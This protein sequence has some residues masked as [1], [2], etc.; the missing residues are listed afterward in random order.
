MV[1]GLCEQSLLS[2]EIHSDLLTYLPLPALWVDRLERAGR[3]K[4]GLYWMVFL[5][6]RKLRLT[7]EI[8]RIW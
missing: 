1:P 3:R 2:R 7:G 8:V 4:D 6:D 5:E